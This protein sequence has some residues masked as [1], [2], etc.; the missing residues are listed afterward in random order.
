M[1]VTAGQVSNIIHSVWS[2]QSKYF[3][4]QRADITCICVLAHQ[5]S[6]ALD[7]FFHELGGEGRSGLPYFL[8]AAMSITATS[9]NRLPRISVTSN[10]RQC[11]T[12]ADSIQQ[13]LQ[14][15]GEDL[16]LVRN[17]A[18]STSALPSCV[19]SLFSRVGAEAVDALHTS[20]MGSV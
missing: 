16:A 10:L 6:G 11:S 13:C 12:S 9:G 14:R 15:F 5:R 3:Q 4:L 8:G 1:A 20:I 18:S 19:W 2:Q 7:P 17:R